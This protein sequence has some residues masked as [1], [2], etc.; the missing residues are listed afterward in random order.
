MAPVLG[1]SE[2]QTRREIDHYRPTGNVRALG[3]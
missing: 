3:Y 1:W 2:H